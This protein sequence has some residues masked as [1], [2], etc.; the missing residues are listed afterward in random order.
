M[1]V[2]KVIGYVVRLT[3]Y[4]PAPLDIEGVLT[5]DGELFRR[6][7]FNGSIESYMR[8]HHPDHEHLTCAYVSRFKVYD[9]YIIVQPTHIDKWLKGVA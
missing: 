3:N 2:E 1:L 7:S 4:E 8:E 5:Y 9:G 6:H